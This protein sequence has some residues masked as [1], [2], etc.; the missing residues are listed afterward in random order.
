M[1][2]KH[3]KLFIS[4]TAVAAAG[5]LGVGA[6]FQTVLSVQ[7]SSEMM[8]GIEQIVS[9]NTEEKPFRILELVNDSADAEIGYYISGQEPTL[10][11]YEYQ[12]TD[13]SGQTQTVHF[14][15]VQDALS[16]LPATRRQEFMQN[17]R[18]N[19][20]GS[21]DSST[22]IKN[23]QS[24]SGDDGP[25]TYTEYQ[26]KYFTDTDDTDWTKVDLTDFS[27]NSRTDT[28]SVNGTYQE[29]SS[30]TGNYTKEEQE[31]YPIRN[32]V[33]ADQEQTGKY[34]ENIQNFHASESSDSR[35]AYY[36]EFVPVSNEKINAE[37]QKDKGQT[38]ILPEYDYANGR[39]GYYENVYTDLTEEIVNDI[40]EQNYQ[41]PGENP[42]GFSKSDEVLIQNNEKEAVQSTIEESNAFTSGEKNSADDSED[43][44]EDS[45]SEASESSSVDFDNAYQ[46]DGEEKVSSGRGRSERKAENVRISCKKRIST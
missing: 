40:N 11:L 5:A 9:E 12:Y 6:L 16:K 34:R 18:I 13:S 30:G 45:F 27:G 39:Y 17:I 33:Q 4:G 35:G 26:E 21:T 2:F 38:A 20:D 19:S 10:K 46:M 29:N 24:I 37:L 1:R 22:G 43:P 41:F 3:K 15:S 31:Y 8:P 32:G 42:V 25:L 28:V 7:A 44:A 36:L 14:S 23:I